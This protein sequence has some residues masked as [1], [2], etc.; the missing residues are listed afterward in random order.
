MEA[1]PV[2]AASPQG[3]VLVEEMVAGYGGTP[4]LTGVDFVAAPGERVALLGPN[5]GGKTTLIRTLQGELSPISGTFSL[6]GQMGHV[7]QKSTGRNDWPVTTLDVAICGT[8]DGLPWWR[9]PGKTQRRSARQALEAVGLGDRSSTPYGELSGGQQRRAQVAAALAGGASILL[10]DEPFAGLDAV[11]ADRLEKLL[12]TLARAGTTILI[13]THDLDQAQ[14]WEKVLCL[15]G[16]QLAFGPPESVLTRQTLEATFGSDLL[17][18]PGGG[19]MAPP[20]HHHD[21]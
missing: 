5:G 9:V 2:S 7:P 17:E 12:A 19:F 8:L 20:H 14:A 18:V 10:L 15:N 13:A 21:H 4:V 1:V 11:A 16:K 3:A 6:D